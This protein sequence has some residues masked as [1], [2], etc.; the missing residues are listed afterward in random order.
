MKN[1]MRNVD[2]AKA[3]A[4][5]KDS[6]AASVFSTTMAATSTN[7]PPAAPNAA[8]K[9]CWLTVTG[10]YLADWMAKPTIAPPAGLELHTGLTA[11]RILPDLLGVR[12]EVHARSYSRRTGNRL[13]SALSEVETCPPKSFRP[14]QPLAPSAARTVRLV[15]VGV[16]VQW[17]LQLIGLASLWPHRAA[18][19][20]LGLSEPGADPL[21]FRGVHG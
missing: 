13:S 9:A 3:A 18:V 2:K 11:G 15:T 19:F 5:P 17:G 20:L 8:A 10:W 6:A 12:P 14:R 4:T 21:H 7:D 16:S 1:A